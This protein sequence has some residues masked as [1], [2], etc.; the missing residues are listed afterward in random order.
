MKLYYSP[1][2]C[3]LSPHIVL[4]EVGQKFDLVKVDLGTHKTAAGEDYYKINPKGAVP[5]LQL[6]DGSLLTEGA[7]IVQYIGDQ[8]AGSTLMPK[9]GT[10]ERYREIEW[11][12]WIAAEMH[13]SMGGLFNKDL[14]AKA[15][16]IIKQRIAA[17]L[18]ILEKHL[19]KNDYLL[20]KT[21]TAADAYAFTVLGWGQ[22]VGVDIKAYPSVAA[23]VGRVAQRPAVQA[24]LKAEHS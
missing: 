3:S 2:A 6:D 4:R 15:G 13:K 16:D 20:G 19:A 24:A 17:Q 5:A 8:A 18:A 7:A 1:G 11:L 22:Y 14:A 10:L 23:Y 12:N 9:A 21:F